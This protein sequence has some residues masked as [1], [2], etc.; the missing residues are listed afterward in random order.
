VRD[1]KVNDIQCDGE[2]VEIASLV[3]DPN[4]ARLHPERNQEAIKQSLLLYGQRS[5]LVV[6]AQNRMI[7]AGNGRREGML[8]LGWTRCAATIR[9]MTD[10]EF[11]GFALAD[12]RTAELAKWDFETVARLDRLQQELEGAEMVGWSKDELEVLRAAEWTP[13]PIEDDQDSEEAESLVVSFS[14]QQY[15]AVAR[16]VAAVRAGYQEGMSQSDSLELICKEWI[17]QKTPAEEPG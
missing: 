6:R 14:A 4:N 9:S 5:P 17:E 12:N 11:I 10:A 16:A 8:A 1:V 3:P 7:A 2:V 15:K 13:P